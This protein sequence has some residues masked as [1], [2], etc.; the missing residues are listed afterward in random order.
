MNLGD[1]TEIDGE[2]EVHC[3]T[4]FQSQ[5]FGL[6]EDTVGAQIA[7]TAQLAGTSRDGNI[8]SSTCS[9]TCMETSLHAQLPEYLCPLIM[10]REGGRAKVH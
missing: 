1:H 10:P 6:D 8:N 4:F 3:R 5:I 7:R 2:G 9:M